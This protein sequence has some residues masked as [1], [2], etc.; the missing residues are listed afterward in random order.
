MEKSTANGLYKQ[1]LKQGGK[2]SFKEWI[3]DQKKDHFLNFN[4]TP[5]IN[6]VMTDKVTATLEK[7]TPETTGGDTSGCGCT[8]CEK[9]HAA[10][11]RNKALVLIGLGVAI[12]CVVAYMYK[13]GK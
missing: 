2:A 5:P 7:I 12:G 1:Y 8:D 9:K 3:N 13:K 10:Q 4:G 11:K 6:Q